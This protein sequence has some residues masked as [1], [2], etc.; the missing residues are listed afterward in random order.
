MKHLSIVVKA[1]WDDE[2]RVWVAS[3]TDIQGL[4]I[5]AQTQED[6][7]EQVIL[8]VQDLLELNGV[9]SDLSEIPVHI[10]SESLSRVLNPC[11]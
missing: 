2:A 1:Q 7:Q 5:E 8:A 6:L 10:M 4:A 11:H 9:E 3:S